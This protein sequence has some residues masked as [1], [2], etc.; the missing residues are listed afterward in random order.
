[1]ATHAMAATNNHAAAAAAAAPG[2]AAA[3]GNNGAHVGGGAMAGGTTTSGAGTITASIPAGIPGTRR[4]ARVDMGKLSEN[5]LS[6]YR[7]VFKLGQTDNLPT[8]D[9]LPS[10][11]RHFASMNSV[12]E[13]D[14][15]LCFAFQVRRLQHHNAI[16]KGVTEKEEARV[17][18]MGGGGA[19]AATAARLAG[20]TN[21]PPSK[22]A[23]PSGRKVK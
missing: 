12:D 16:V 11:Q 4:A 23:R 14:T 6:R 22:K 18:P 7:R 1:M 19:P 10:V 8:D 9:M 20:Y 5:S 17:G 3:D 2:L 15:L 13:E 21:E